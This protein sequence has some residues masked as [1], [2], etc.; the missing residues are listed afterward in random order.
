MDFKVLEK[1]AGFLIER[2]TAPLLESKKALV[3]GGFMNM[4]AQKYVSGKHDLLTE[5][6]DVVPILLKEYHDTFHA[7]VK[8]EAEEAPV[9]EEVIVEEVI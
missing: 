3:K 2:F 7:E 6:V 1:L 8:E 4:E 9:A 5:L